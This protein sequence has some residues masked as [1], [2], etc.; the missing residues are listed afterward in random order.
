MEN[1][2]TIKELP[3]EWIHKEGS[4]LNIIYDIPKM[5]IDIIKIKLKQ[6]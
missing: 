3:I 5:L 2:I 6:K 1:N 4:K